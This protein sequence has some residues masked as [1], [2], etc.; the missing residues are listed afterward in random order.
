MSVRVQRVKTT[1]ANRPPRG[2]S[3]TSRR[4][5]RLRRVASQE[6]AACRVPSC[7]KL[8]AR[9]LLAPCEADA[10]ACVPDTFTTNSFRSRVFARGSLAAGSTGIG[11]ICVNPRAFAQTSASVIAGTHSQAS[12]AGTTIDNNDATVG[13]D[14]FASNSQITLSSSTVQKRIVGVGLRVRYSGT[15][16]DC[17]GTAYALYQP[18]AVTLN[19]YNSSNMAGL[20]ECTVTPITT[21][22]KW[23][24]V[25]WR[26][27]DESDYSFDAGV[28][29]ATATVAGT[30]ILGIIVDG[31]V[32][33]STC[34][35]EVVGHYEY[36]GDVANKKPS[37][38]DVSVL[39]AVQTVAANVARRT[40]PALTQQF[41]SV[42]M[43]WAQRAG[44]ALGR[45]G[46]A[47]LGRAL[48]PASSR[49]S[50][51]ISSMQRLAIEL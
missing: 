23:I 42:A 49:G 21:Q 11:F 20:Q 30:V 36:I 6:D 37:E 18:S 47:A 3:A 16:L 29:G 25:N 4:R 9:A 45:A 26:P 32:A 1:L 48:M 2:R 22:R 51:F 38:A 13:V 50:N 43:E 34:Y 28:D 41:H 5:R 44:V 33:G 35:W 24:T 31:M 8:Y 12:Y 19:G 40:P 7:L 39:S 27:V 46:I 10:G 15:E 14:G 17:A